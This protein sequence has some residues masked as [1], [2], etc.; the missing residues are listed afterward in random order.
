MA[1]VGITKYRLAASSIL[2]VVVSMVIIVMVLGISLMIYSNVVRQSLSARQL[3]AQF[4]LQQALLKIDNSSLEQIDAVD[5]W[6]II[7]EVKPY[8]ADT[9]LILVH[10]TAYDE[11]HNLIAEI[12]KVMIGHEKD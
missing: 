7:R 9:H 10:L 8:E 11:G 12:R 4:L 2:E 3:K 5:Q 6:Q 1:T